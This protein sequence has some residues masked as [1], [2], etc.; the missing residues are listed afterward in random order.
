[1]KEVTINH[2]T[3]AKTYYVYSK[4][5]ADE[6]KIE[7]KHWRHGDEGDYIISDDGIVAKVI[8][9]RR[10][11]TSRNGDKDK[12]YYRCA[13]GSTFL[14]PHLESQKM[15]AEGRISRYDVGK[16]SSIERAMSSNLMK[17]LAMVYAMTMNHEK[18]IT[19]VFPEASRKEYRQLKRR[20]CT[21]V[22]RN[23]VR[24]ELR[25]HLEE[26]GINEAKALKFLKE[27]IEIAKEKKDVTNMLR[28][29]ENM[30]SILGMETKEKQST[31]L[32]ISTGG[33]RKL[34]DMLNDEEAKMTLT[35]KVERNVEVE[36]AGEDNGR[37]VVDAEA[38]EIIQD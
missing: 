33:N 29:F 21:K 37:E 22:F 28:A 38:V 8:V 13:W 18:T 34:I 31:T 11:P 14:F 19:H 35:H 30:K 17:N 6:A 16:I 15:K 26:A 36:E 3:G 32:Q 5:E 25:E 9:K 23:M 27:I 2:P 1:M 12:Y 4:E 20:M 10:Y 24:Q 7:Y